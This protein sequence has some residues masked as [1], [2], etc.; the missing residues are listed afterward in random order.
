MERTRNP[1]AFAI[2]LKPETVTFNGQDAFIAITHCSREY[3]TSDLG[4]LLL[5]NRWKSIDVGRGLCS[6]RRSKIIR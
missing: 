3:Q 2:C 6:R 5:S 1:V 4:D